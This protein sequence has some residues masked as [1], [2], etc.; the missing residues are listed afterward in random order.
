[1]A[2][3]DKR[4]MKF[5][6]EVFAKDEE[7]QKEEKQPRKSAKEIQEE[8]QAQRE[9]EREDKR[10]KREETRKIIKKMHTQKNKKGQPLMKNYIE[11]ALHKLENE[12]K[13]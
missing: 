7:Q 1:M 5:Y 3:G 11:Y 9:Q 8:R 13:K 12:K 2:E 10:V 6:D 4:R